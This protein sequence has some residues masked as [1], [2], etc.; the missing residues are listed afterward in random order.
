MVM[1][2]FVSTEEQ[3]LAQDVLRNIK[4]LLPRL[5]HVLGLGPKDPLPDSLRR[6][7]A[8]GESLVKNGNYT[9]S[10]TQLKSVY[11]LMSG[12]IPRSRGIP[13]KKFGSV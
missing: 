13:V 2:K 1:V 3:R 5:K 9:A 4:N 10:L 7:I 11:L 8:F 6:R 12:L